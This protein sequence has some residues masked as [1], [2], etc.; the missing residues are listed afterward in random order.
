MRFGLVGTGFWAAET[1]ATA[2]QAHPDIDFVG[3]WGRSPDRT[4]ELAARFSVRAYAAADDM[5]ADVDAVAFAVPPDVQADLA[6]R[7]A[8]HGCHLLLDKPL[9]LTVA[10]ADAMV[11]AV[12]RA[13]VRSIVFFTSRFVPNVNSWLT[14]A[15]RSNDWHAAHVRLWTS[16]FEPGN[17]F[18][19]SP[20][21]REKGAL[22]DIGPHAL[23][24]VMPVLGPVER[25][26]ALPGLGDAVEVV[27]RHTS[28]ATSTLSLS[29]TAPLGSRGE[30]T[31]FY[32]AADQARPPA[33]TSSPLEAMGHCITALTTTSAEPWTHP[34]DASFGRDVVKVLAAAETCMTQHSG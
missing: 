33:A 11:A 26:V 2:L 14:T 29:L 5:F 9:A 31:V 20:W 32:G 21:R 18:G 6:V 12:E 10:D 16:I 1:H 24:L 7:A 3:A 8:G 4:E 34:C 30:D 27:A 19:A 13:K 15:S 17:P 28:G 22:W 25:V 23:A